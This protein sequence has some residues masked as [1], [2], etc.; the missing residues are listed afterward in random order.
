MSLRKFANMLVAIDG[1]HHSIKAAEYALNLAKIYGAT[2]HAVTVSYIPESYHM[3][4]EDTIDKS[5]T[6]DSIHDAKSWFEKFKQTAKE[7]NISLKPELINSHRPIDY[8]L[9]DH[10]WNGRDWDTFK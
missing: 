9:L 7:N 5:R 8:V 3:K 4:Q 2:L 1:S 6:G 10:A